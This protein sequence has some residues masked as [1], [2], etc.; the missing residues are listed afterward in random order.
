MKSQNAFI[1]I[2]LA[3]ALSHQSLRGDDIDSLLDED[4]IEANEDR[5]RDV[6]KK[7]KRSKPLATNSTETEFKIDETSEIEASDPPSSATRSEP[8]VEMTES[9]PTSDAPAEAPPPPSSSEGEMADEFLDGLDDSSETAEESPAPVQFQMQSENNFGLDKSG[10]D[11]GLSELSLDDDNT[12]DDNSTGDDSMDEFGLGGSEPAEPPA[13]EAS[14]P[15]EEDKL[16]EII[17]NRFPV[18][19]IKRSSS[20]RVYL[21]DDTT[22]ARPP[23]GAIVLLKQRDERKMAFRIIKTYA[24]DGKEEFAARRVRTYNGIEA[25][26]DGE[27]Y[28]AVLKIRDFVPTAK[29]T[30]L[31]TRDEADLLELEGEGDGAPVDTAVNQDPL[32]VV[33][34][35]DSELDSGSSPDPALNN[36]NTDE[37]LADQASDEIMKDLTIET[38]PL[39]DPD[40]HAISV[41]GGLFQNIGPAPTNGTPQDAAFYAGP[42]F[43]YG[44]T[45]VKSF[46]L[47]NNTVQD[48]LVLEGSAAW[49]SA[50]EFINEQSFFQVLRGA[51]QL[52]YNLHFGPKLVVFG[53]A[54]GN[55]SQV[56]VADAGSDAS[57][58]ELGFLNLSRPGIGFGGGLMLGFG[59]RWFLRTDIG[60]D[61][62]GA[63]L[64]LRF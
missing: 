21:L 60:F 41:G 24:D 50:Q 11:D 49:Y 35:F 22:K 15:T 19:T 25:L 32:P 8:L 42:F 33:A 46:L 26:R 52:Q 64:V 16:P 37:W 44:L 4:G 40:R 47:A 5:A 20:N 48:S 7:L 12:L 57:A 6:R 51:V 58:A 62:I 2:V 45:L 59:P 53:Y 23:T 29:I 56:I 28:D 18:R 34:E 31:T 17:A 3:L 39:F 13:T 30:P 55:Y 43:R 1:A 36:V 54:G 10:S 38:V 9:P 63:G 14:A 27:N 61:F